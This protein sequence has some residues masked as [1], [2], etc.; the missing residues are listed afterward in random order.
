MSTQ[1]ISVSRVYADASAIRGAEWYDYDSMNLTWG[2]SGAYLVGQQ[3]GQGRFSKVFEGIHTP[4][5]TSVILKILE[6][7]TKPRKVQREVKILQNL[8]DGR[9]II[10]LL[11]I[12]QLSNSPTLVFERVDDTVG[13]GALLPGDVRFYMRQLLLALDWA[14]SRGIMHRDVKPGNVVIDHARRQLRLIDWGIAEF[15]HPRRAYNVRVS[16]LHYKAPELLAGYQY[17]DYAIDLWSFGCIFAA[18]VFR[19][20]AFFRGTDKASQ[21]KRIAKVLGTDDLWLCLEKYDVLLDEEVTLTNRYP[22]QPWSAFVALENAQFIS[23]DAIGL[24]DGLF[25]YDHAERLTAREALQHRY[26]AA[27]Q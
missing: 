7:A 15:Y 1:V 14:H 25:K 24:L 10:R 11:D 6:T 13:F 9:N 21:L 22:R 26:F 4:T 27:V 19:K 20:D 23:D 5:S 17:Y 12:F 16:T 18:L 2:D 3:V 8:R